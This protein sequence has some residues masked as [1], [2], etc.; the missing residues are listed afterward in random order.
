VAA[1]RCDFLANA[2]SA[3]SRLV[4]NSFEPLP[5][6]NRKLYS[7]NRVQCRFIGSAAGQCAT[8]VS[9]SEN[10]L[11]KVKGSVTVCMSWFNHSPG[12]TTHLVQLLTWFNHSPGSVSHLAQPL[13][14]FSH[15]PGS[16]THLVQSLTGMYS[17]VICE[18]AFPC[19]HKVTLVAFECRVI[20]KSHMIGQSVRPFTFVWTVR[21]F[22]FGLSVRSLGSLR[23]FSRFATKKKENRH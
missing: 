7:G 10:A 5:P 8:N 23:C 3:P 11:H 2:C 14:W 21:T 9:S 1:S 22:I 17:F 6:L 19:C 15:S 16:T 12:S 18:I 4:L 13:T 20:V